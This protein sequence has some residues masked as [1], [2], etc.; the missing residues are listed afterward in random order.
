MNAMLIQNM[1]TGIPAYFDIRT[2]DLIN[3]NNNLKQTFMKKGTDNFTKV[4]KE[5]LDNYAAADEQFA[6]KY[7]S[8]D[9]N[10][11]DCIQFILGT[12]KESGVSGFTDDEVY[13]MALHYYDEENIEIKE[14][15]NEATVVVNH[16]VKLTEE[17]IAAAR[18][19]AIDQLAAEVK[20]KMQR[21][22]TAKPTEQKQQSLF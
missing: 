9:K 13:G 5:Y 17:E 22:S 15:F 6:A 21:K 3:T 7:A 8:P 20:A 2:G 4:I 19:Q 16:K 11:E 18:K 10:I 1:F 14:R 12:V